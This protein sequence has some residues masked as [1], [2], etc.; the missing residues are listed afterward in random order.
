MQ[1]YALKRHGI[2]GAVDG[3]G[4]TGSMLGGVSDL[5]VHQ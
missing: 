4:S 5:L 1:L 2:A 3:G